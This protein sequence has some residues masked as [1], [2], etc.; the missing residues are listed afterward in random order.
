MSEPT[1]IE[2]PNIYCAGHDKT[3]P[4]YIICKHI[5][6]RHDVDYVELASKTNMGVVACPVC[7]AKGE[8]KEA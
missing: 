3:G 8:D 6:T 1:T 2:F 7:A 4:G 5:K